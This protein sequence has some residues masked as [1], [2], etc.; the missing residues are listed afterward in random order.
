MYINPHYLLGDVARIPI[1]FGALV[2]REI[3]GG[4]V[5]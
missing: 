3:K 5:R 4:V 1:D 2:A